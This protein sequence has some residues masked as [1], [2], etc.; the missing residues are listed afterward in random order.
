M[1]FD[2]EV[3]PRQPAK[4]YRNM[5]CDD[6]GCVLKPVYSGRDDGTAEC[7]QPDDGLEIH[8][9]GGYGMAIDP[10]HDATE[11]DLTILFCAKCTIK[12]AQLYPRIAECLKKHGGLGHHCSKEKQYVWRTY[13]ECCDSYC[14]SCGKFG[15]SSMGM[16]VEDDLYSRSIIS[17]LDCGHEGPGL[18][19]WEHPIEWRA[20]CEGTGEYK[21]FKS[22]GEAEEFRQ[23]KAAEGIEVFYTSMM[24]IPPL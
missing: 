22:R 11:Q 10:I 8:L 17:C 1:G 2:V 14:N 3:M 6:C 24:Q 7:L 18:W 20:E 4:L 5:T 15:S 9:M 21:V 16:E 13:S 23:A 19:A 12:L